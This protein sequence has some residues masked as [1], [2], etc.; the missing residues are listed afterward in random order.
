MSLQRVSVEIGSC[1]EHQ[2]DG[3]CVNLVGLGFAQGQSFTELIGL[4]RVENE[5][6]QPFVQQKTE[7]MVGIMP[8]RFEPDS[9]LG[10]VAT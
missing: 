8:S 2:S 6:L 5:S 7:K 3:F 10:V 1:H 4:N 9:Y